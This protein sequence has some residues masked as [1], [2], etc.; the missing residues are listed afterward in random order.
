MW[1]AGFHAG[2]KGRESAAKVALAVAIASGSQMEARL[3]NNYPEFGQMLDGGTASAR[4]FMQTQQKRKAI[5][6]PT[7]T[8]NSTSLPINWIA[9]EG[10]SSI[11][12]QGFIA[13]AP[14][15]THDK[16]FSSIFSNAAHI[17]GALL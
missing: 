7:P 17:L 3:R 10:V 2:K 9:I 11:L 14:A 16:T 15:I 13:E 6:A 1:A 5:E 8:M 12:Q 4:P